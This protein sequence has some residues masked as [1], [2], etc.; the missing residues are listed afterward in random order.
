MTRVALALVILFNLTGCT[1]NNN[2]TVFELSCW[3]HL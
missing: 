1:R 3:S 2:C